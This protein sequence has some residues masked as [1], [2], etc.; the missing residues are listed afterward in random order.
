MKEQHQQQ[1]KQIERM[2]HSTHIQNTEH[3]KTTMNGMTEGTKTRKKKLIRMVI[4]IY[5]NITYC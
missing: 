1:Q 3:S 4:E 5:V 2:L